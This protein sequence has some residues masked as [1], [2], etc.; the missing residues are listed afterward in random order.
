MTNLLLIFHIILCVILIGVVMLQSGKGTD[1]AAVF[2]GGSQTVFGSRGP[3]TFLNK[4][5]V[6][7]ALLFLL[8]SLGMARIA[9]NASAKS[10]IDQANLEQTLPAEETPATEPTTETKGE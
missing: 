6:V 5:T 7:I 4:I 3:A 8:T 2:G 1:I 9:R 10:V